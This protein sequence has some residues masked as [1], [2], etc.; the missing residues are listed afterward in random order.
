MTNTI[1]AYKG[2][3]QN[4]QCR[5][6]QYVEGETYE[7]T[8]PIKVCHSG[9]HAVTMPLDVLRYYKPGTSQYHVVEL[10]DVDQGDEEDSKVAARKIRIGAK[11]DLTG[12]IKAQVEFVFKNAKPV[13]GATSA[14]NNAAVR[15]A[16][17]NGAATASGYSGAATASGRSGAATASGDKSVA[18]ASGYAGKARGKIGTALFLTERDDECSIIGVAAVVVDGE[19][20][21]ADTFY[22]LV[23]GVVV[24]VP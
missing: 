18:L 5:G 13:K 11:L 8:G 1:T 17:S 3:D 7:H 12:L 9:F 14:K 15:V 16:V 10:E 19:T 23:G 21:K 24:E 6:F 20:Y 22:Q 4:M 2:F